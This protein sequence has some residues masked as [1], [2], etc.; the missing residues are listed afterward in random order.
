M[1]TRKLAASTLILMLQ[2]TIAALPRAA[3]QARPPAQAPPAQTPPAPAPQALDDEALARE[4]ITNFAA[5]KFD[6]VAARFGPELAAVLPADRLP[7]SWDSALAQFGTFVSIVS[8]RSEQVQG[9]TVV[10]VVCKFSLMEAEFTMP[11][12]AEQHLVGLHGGR[13]TIPWSAPEYVK[14]D[15][16]S[17]RSV[18]VGSA[19]WTLPGTLTLPKGPGPFPAVVLVH[20]SGAGAGDP[21]ETIGPNKAFKDLAW[22]WPAA[23]SPCSGTRNAPG[24]TAR[25]FRRISLALR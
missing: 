6:A 18:T 9:K 21:D 14:L 19:P 25:K 24:S 20:G 16:Y 4:I 1:R 15:A 7:A 22:D 11:F 3:A 10:H 23:A 12:D 13:L 5:R 8:V 17:E 2:G